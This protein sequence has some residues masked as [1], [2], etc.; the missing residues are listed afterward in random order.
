MKGFGTHN[1]RLIEVLAHIPD[2]PHMTKLRETYNT[3]FK[4]DLL[5]DL[6]SETSGHFREGLLG[7]ARGPLDQD[8]YLA[9]HALSGLGTKEHL[10]DDTLLG[11]S[12][13]DMK[14]IKFA[15]HKHY[16]RDLK[17][18][19][20]QDLSLKTEKLFE[21]V[22]AA[23][24]AEENQPINYAEIED[25]VDRLYNATEGQSW[26][27]NAD[28]VCQIF[29]FSSD[30]QLRAINQRYQQ[31]YRHDLDHIV[32]HNFSGHMEHALRLMLARAVDRIKCDADQMEHA[33]SGIG[34]HDTLLVERMVRAHAMGTEHMRQVGIA[35]KQ[36][37][38]QELRNRIHGETSGHSRDLM[39]ALCP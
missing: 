29:A 9:H 39:L 11:R 16:T 19:V 31:K 32:K 27:H 21:Y 33:M 25:K 34:T 35:Y 37:H 6:H 10:L 30:G 20:S 14:A 8:V 4:R 28:A 1:K 23:D 5:K 3:Q 2:P 26:G 13:A 36:F 15:F 24:R 38:G 18:E 7:L 12:N 17:A 22:L